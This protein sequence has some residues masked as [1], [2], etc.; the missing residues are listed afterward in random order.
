MTTMVAGSRSSG[1]PVGKV[2]S[3]IA[4]LLLTFFTLGIYWIV[5]TYSTLEELRNWRGQGWSGVLY[6]LFLLLF[7]LPL[8]ALPWLIP[9]YV[10]RMYA[11]EGRA[12]PITGLS[13]FWV[14]LPLLGGVVWVFVIQNRLNGFW[15]S[16]SVPEV[17]HAPAP[18]RLQPVPT[19][20]L[21]R[22]P[23]RR[24]PEASAPGPA[25]SDGLAAASVPA[26]EAEELPGALTAR[27]DAQELRR[28]FSASSS[29]AAAEGGTPQVWEP[30]SRGLPGFLKVGIPLAALGVAAAIYVLQGKA[31]MPAQYA[32]VLPARQ[33]PAA[34][35]RQ[36]PVVRYATAT[37]NVRETPSVQGRVLF[38]LEQGEGVQVE[39]ASGVTRDGYEWVVVSAGTGRKGWAARKFFAESRR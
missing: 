36:V 29:P 39:A 14:F 9:A 7:G 38:R 23:E 17:S 5:Y 8:I 34:P 11:E 1:R 10:G 19:H 6:L 3:P 35:A 4:V 15:Q 22:E 25:A 18:S 24:F 16:V 26:A 12:K 21:R 13:G 30:E 32:S 27:D 20:D 37:V 28:A 2:R 31:T 33:A